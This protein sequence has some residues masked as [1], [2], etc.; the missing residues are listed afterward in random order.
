MTQD[1]GKSLAGATGAE[2]FNEMLLEEGVALALGFAQT[3][4]LLIEVEVRF[5]RRGDVFEHGFHPGI[6]RQF[7]LAVRAIDLESGFALLP[8]KVVFLLRR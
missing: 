3:L 1:K 2:I 5:I 7:R 8:H 4:E 6:Y